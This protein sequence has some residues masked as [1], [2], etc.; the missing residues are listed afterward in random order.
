MS[1]PEKLSS[2]T[3][4]TN[5]GRSMDDGR[6]TALKY[7]EQRDTPTDVY[8]QWE[9]HEHNLKALDLYYAWRNFPVKRMTK[10][11]TLQRASLSAVRASLTVVFP[12]SREAT[13][14]ENCLV[15]LACCIHL[16]VWVFCFVFLFFV[17]CTTIRSTCKPSSIIKPASRLVFVST[18]CQPLNS[19]A[20][21]LLIRWQA[22]VQRTSSI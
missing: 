2:L 10:T 9:A 15:M 3:W 5:E 8:V 20:V 13:P 1:V 7:W 17:Q 4:Q 22:M 19:S 21:Q 18:R 6:G 14:M 11:G 16:C 12:R